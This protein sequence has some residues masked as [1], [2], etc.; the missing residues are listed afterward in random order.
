MNN[1]TFDEANHIYKLSGNVIP[2]VT[3]IISESGFVDLSFVN[4]E[5]LAWKGDLGKKVHKATELYDQDDLNIETLNPTLKSY[6]DGWIK[7]EN[8][9][10]FNVYN[11]ELEMYHPLYKF[12]GRLDRIGVIAQDK[13]YD[14]VLVDIKS[15]VKMKHHAI[16]L[17]GYEL[18]YNYGKPRFE[19]IK[20]RLC[21]YLNPDGYRV[22]EYKNVNDANV[23]LAALTMHNF[24][25]N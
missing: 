2:G 13:K 24:K 3:Q 8:D 20:R 6:L 11:I 25:N 4:E 1:F 19:Q 18:L 21:V 12:A 5:Y 16:Q 15:G 17:A 9:Y 23:F 10:G 7:F 14:Y 22:E